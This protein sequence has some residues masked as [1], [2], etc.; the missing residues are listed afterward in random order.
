[1][2]H[3]VVGPGFHSPGS[4]ANLNPAAG[5]APVPVG[6]Q[7]CVFS[8]TLRTDH[9]GLLYHIGICRSPSRCDNR[10]RITTTTLLH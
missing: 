2:R 4:S 5:A 7:T 9:L 6:A 1:M 3:P 8:N 10:L